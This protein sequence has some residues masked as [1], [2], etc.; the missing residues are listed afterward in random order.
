MENYNILLVHN[1][2]KVSGGED[3]VFKNEKKML[4]DN[5]NVVYEYTRDNNEINSMKLMHKILLPFINIFSL[6]TYR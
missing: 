1:F 4:I 6:K 3:T 5:G 2:Y